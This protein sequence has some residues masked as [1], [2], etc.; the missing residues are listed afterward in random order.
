MKPINLRTGPT[1]TAQDIC[2][3]TGATRCLEP[4]RAGQLEPSK[5]ALEAAA[6]EH[7]RRH[8]ARGGKRAADY[9]ACAHRNGGWESWVVCKSLGE[10]RRQAAMWRDTRRDIAIWAVVGPDGVHWPTPTTMR[11]G[12][13]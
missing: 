13:E 3:G 7:Y 11:G 2:H 5:A 1:G 4:D 12:G 10:A 8:A 6:R 9:L